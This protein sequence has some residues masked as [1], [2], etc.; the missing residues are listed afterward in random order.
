VPEKIAP[1][2]R[3][4]VEAADCVFD[5]VSPRAALFEFAGPAPQLEW[6]RSV[7]MTGEGSLATPTLGVAAWISTV[8]GR[9]TQID[10]SAIELEGIVAGAFRFA[11]EQRAVPSDA[12]VLDSEA[13]RRSSASPGIRASALPGFRISKVSERASGTTDEAEAVKE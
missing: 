1:A 6:L 3:V 10:P 9:I 13:P 12:V 7:K 11:G 2:G 8:D 5:I 4:L